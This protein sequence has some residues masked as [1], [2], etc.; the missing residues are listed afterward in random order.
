[1]LIVKCDGLR[2]ACSRCAERNKDCV[3][4]STP[5][6]SRYRFACW[7][8]AGHLESD[9]LT[10]TSRKRKPHDDDQI[11][12]LEDQIAIL[13]SYARHLQSNAEASTLGDLEDKS[14]EHEASVQDENDGASGEGEY[15]GLADSSCTPTSRS[16]A[17]LDG[18]LPHAV[19]ELSRLLWT[20]HIGKEG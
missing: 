17:D 4:Q 14:I 19:D 16:A 3:Y 15:D 5:L 10:L 7:S 12:A 13:K 11:K 9:R 6:T 18:R 2:P 1:M 20:T 8:S